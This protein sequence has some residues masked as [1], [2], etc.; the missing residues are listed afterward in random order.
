MSMVNCWI[1][2]TF[3]G[4]ITAIVERDVRSYKVFSMDHI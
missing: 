4:M 2:R 3:W 1:S